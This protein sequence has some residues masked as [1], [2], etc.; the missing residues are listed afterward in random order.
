MTR[1]SADSGGCETVD[2]DQQ[3]LTREAPVARTGPPGPQAGSETDA[4]DVCTAKQLADRL[5]V[6]EQT[7]R[8]A[9]A[10]RVVPGWQLP[11]GHWRFSFAQVYEWLAGPGVP[12]GPILKA[13]DLAPLIGTTHKTVLNNAAA[14]GTP[15]KLPGRLV[16]NQWL[17]AVQAVRLALPRPS[18]ALA[19][20]LGVAAGDAGPPPPG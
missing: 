20:R 11:S 19:E 10:A 5:G 3:H 13:R 7:I 15:D 8:K 1:D 6:H 12:Y 14:P 9:A 4:N 18:A 17:F 16:G 2:P